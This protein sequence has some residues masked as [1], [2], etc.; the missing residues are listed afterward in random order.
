M[1]SK[2]SGIELEPLS[3]LE[4]TRKYWKFVLICSRRPHNCKK[5]ISRREKNEMHKMEIVRAKHAKLEGG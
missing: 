5:V 2:Y 4:I 1:Y 3:G